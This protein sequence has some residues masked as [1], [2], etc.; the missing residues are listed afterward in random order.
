M[1]D[2]VVPH[3]LRNRSESIDEQAMTKMMGRVL[4]ENVEKPDAAKGPTPPLSRLDVCAFNSS[5]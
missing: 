2:R 1:N 4:P 5:I 3:R